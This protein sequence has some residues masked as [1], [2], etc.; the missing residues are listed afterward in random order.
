[1]EIIQVAKKGY[2][3]CDYQCVIPLNEYCFYG[4]LNMV[5][6]RVGNLNY[7]HSI[8]Y[9]SLPMTCVLYVFIA[10]I[11]IMFSH[12]YTFFSYW[13]SLNSNSMNNA[14]VLC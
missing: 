1:M 14:W 9:C 2:G 3:S 8:F 5:R 13:E 12:H 10:H 6:S 11:F 4:M 7:F